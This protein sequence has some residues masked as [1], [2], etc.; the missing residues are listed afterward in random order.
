MMI[1]I[2]VIWVEY[3]LARPESKLETKVRNSQ[4]ERK[5]NSLGANKRHC[6]R[7]VNKVVRNEIVAASNVGQ[8]LLSPQFNFIHLMA[9]CSG[10]LWGGNRMNG[11]E[12]RRGRKRAEEKREWVREGLIWCWTKNCWKCFLIFLLSAASQPQFIVIHFYDFH[13]INV[14]TW[15]FVNRLMWIMAMLSSKFV[16]L[17]WMALRDNRLWPKNPPI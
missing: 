14:I 4:S 17:I 13:H 6:A 8:F 2:Y 10:A 15:N 9:R 11:K 12:R 16:H 1:V 5:C 3:S 7:N